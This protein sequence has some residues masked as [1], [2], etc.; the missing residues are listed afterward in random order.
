MVTSSPVPVQFLARYRSNTG[1]LAHTY[2][3]GSPRPWTQSAWTPGSGDLRL[4]TARVRKM[5]TSKT[6]KFRSPFKSLLIR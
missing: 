3:G 1:D 6:V 5:N 2:I 4:D